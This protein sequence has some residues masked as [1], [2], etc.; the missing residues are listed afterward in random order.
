MSALFGYLK[1]NGMRWKEAE[2]NGDFIPSSE[3]FTM[4]QGKS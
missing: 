4:E 2:W 1:I 3:Y